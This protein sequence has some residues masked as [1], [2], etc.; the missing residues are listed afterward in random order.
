M[1]LEGIQEMMNKGKSSLCKDLRLMIQEA[2]I[3]EYNLN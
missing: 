1:D 2:E 3:Y